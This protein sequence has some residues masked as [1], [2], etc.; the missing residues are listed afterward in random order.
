MLSIP[1]QQTARYVKEHGKEVTKEEK[2]TINKVLNYDTIGKIMIQ[3]Y[4][5][6]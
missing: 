5:I 4:L 2:M 3:I 1:F 6:Q